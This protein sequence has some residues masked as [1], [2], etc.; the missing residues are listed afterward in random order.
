[1]KNNTE[2]ID[3][4]LSFL[5]ELKSDKE[6]T[7]HFK[8]VVKD[9]D[10]ASCGM[11]CCMTGWLPIIFPDK[12]EYDL[13]RISLNLINVSVIGDHFVLPFETLTGIPQY[14]GSYLIN[15]DYLDQQEADAL[16]L[17]YLPE[18]ILVEDYIDA[19]R[20]VLEKDL[21]KLD[22]QIAKILYSF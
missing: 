15:P 17:M 3:K 21:N 7:F 16:G 4:I 5:E 12:C 1:M 10:E 20:L 6:R 9:H 2:N 19:F 22:D 11:H 8:E 13:S 18:N 14:V